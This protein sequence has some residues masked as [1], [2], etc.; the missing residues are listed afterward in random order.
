[1]SACR[2][3]SEI[4]KCKKLVISEFGDP[5]KVVKLQ[6]DDLKQPND[7]E[8]LVQMMVASINP[9]DINTVQGKYPVKPELPGVPGFE[10]VGKI[11]QVGKNVKDLSVNDVV[12]PNI[13][14]FG[15]WRTHCVVKP[16]TV[17]KIPNDVPLIEVAGISSNTSTAYR[18]LKDFVDLKPG[19]CVVQNG[20]NSAAGQNVIQFC[21]AWGIQSINVVRNR[22]DIEELKSYLTELGATYVL[23]EEEFR[24][25]ELIKS[26]QVP[27]AKLALNCV[28]GKSASE[29][30]RKLGQ[31]GVIVTY[32]GM[33]REPVIIP[34]SLL[35]FKDIEARG[36]WMTRWTQENRHSEARK[37]MYNEIMGLMKQGKIK[38][39]A[40][41]LI[42]LDNYREALESTSTSKGF[43]GVKFIID[44][45]L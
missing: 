11:V 30:M 36:Y 40:H 22:P 18:M 4:T 5:I 42:S 34:T 24:S 28:G 25:T 16:N 8:V 20:G 43:A 17:L 3:F 39:P 27:P 35:I 37:Q 38:A 19:D 26:K 10:G 13:E 2:S 29:L 14:A 12:I 45:R 33:S 1:M 44:F 23:T 21:K 31:K 32:G 41:K 15:T 9:A 7:D 6:E